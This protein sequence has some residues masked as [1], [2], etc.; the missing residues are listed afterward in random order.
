[1][2]HTDKDYKDKHVPFKRETL[3]LYAVTDQSWLHG[4]TIYEQIEEALQGGATCLQLREK[5]LSRQQFLEE[6]K[7]VKKICA[8]YCVPLIIND[9]VEIARLTDADGVHVGQ[10]DMEVSAARIALGT[11]KIIG[12]SARTVEQALLAQENGADYLGVGAVFPTATK[13]DAS[14]LQKGQLQA[15]CKAVSIPVVAIGGITKENLYQLKGS[16]ICGVA[17]VSA[18]F[19]QPDIIQAAKELKE[20][21][22]KL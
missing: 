6:A 18:I 13:S 10:K 8:R 3:L 2:E 9:D 5:G 14:A 4:R 12:V 11:D 1:M 16:G 7:E 21:A 22:A 15:I 19:A 20:K 17:V